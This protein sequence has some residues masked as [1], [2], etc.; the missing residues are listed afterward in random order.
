MTPFDILIYSGYAII[1]LLVMLVI[2][3]LSREDIIDLF[4]KDEILSGA[5]LIGI[6]WPVI[7][8]ML[9]IFVPFVVLSTIGKILRP[10]LMKR[11]F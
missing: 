2:I 1:G 3:W 6:I 8:A 10:I 9:L 11:I 5:L 7:A 4:R